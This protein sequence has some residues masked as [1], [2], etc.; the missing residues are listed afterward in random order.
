MR[1][2]GA[3]ACLFL[4]LCISG[5]RSEEESDKS[6]KVVEHVETEILVEPETCTETSDVGDTLH[7]HYTGKLL[8]GQVFDTSLSRDPLVVEL[9]R[10]TVIPGLEQGLLG[11][12]AGQKLKVTIPP[13][14][15]YGKRGFPPSIPSDAALEFEVDV[16]TLSKQ[17]PWQRVVNNVIPLVCLALVPGLL[18][19][20]GVYLYTKSSTPKVSK[21][22][23]KEEKKK[24]K[25]K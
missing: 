8:N 18:C 17:T 16:V 25:K 15:A 13:H 10:K 6:Q 21:K 14:M 2:W 22:K 4:M 5:L 24:S 20:I 11:V 12:C 1:L 19:L 23:L 7:I 3:C 9:G